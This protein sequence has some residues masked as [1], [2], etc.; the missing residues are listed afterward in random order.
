MIEQ[1]KCKECMRSVG[2]DEITKHGCLICEEIEDF[3]EECCKHC[4]HHSLACEEGDQL[5][6]CMEV[7]K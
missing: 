7:T 2:R 4:N 5:E 6:E 1:T 3:K